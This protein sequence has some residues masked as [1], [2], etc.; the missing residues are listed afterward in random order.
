MFIVVAPRKGEKPGYILV[1]LQARN[2]TTAAE[3][4]RVGGLLVP[5]GYTFKSSAIRRPTNSTGVGSNGQRR[6][7]KIRF[8]QTDS[9]APMLV[10]S[11]RRHFVRLWE[12][13]L[14]G[15]P[16]P[17]TS[18]SASQTPAPRTTAKS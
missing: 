12:A 2:E 3:A 1:M 16:A 17:S 18:H 11:A 15:A 8:N 4:V 5:D 6:S 9:K 7:V 14:G 10:P 13:S